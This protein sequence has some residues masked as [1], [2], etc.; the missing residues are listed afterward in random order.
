MY[1]KKNILDEDEEKYKHCL[2]KLKDLDCP[3]LCKVKYVKDDDSNILI[4]M[5]KY[6]ESLENKSN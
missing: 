2:E 6:P 4:V 1:S 3:N 5:C